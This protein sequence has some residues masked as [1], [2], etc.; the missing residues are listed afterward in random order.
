LLV[1]K[2]GCLVCTAVNM[3]H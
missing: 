2:A 3:H 1:D